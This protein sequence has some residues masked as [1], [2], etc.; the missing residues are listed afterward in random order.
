MIDQL[1]GIGNEHVARPIYSALHGVESVTM[2]LTACKN[3]NHGRVNAPVRCCPN[4]GGVVNV[5]IAIRRCSEMGHAQKRQNRD[6][7]CVDCGE[8][9]TK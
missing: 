6:R 7:F 9:L 1:V 4:C 5:E 3:F 8:Q 2:K